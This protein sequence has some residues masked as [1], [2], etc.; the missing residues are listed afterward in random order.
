MR[1]KLTMNLN[2]SFSMA[3]F[4]MVLISGVTLLL[5]LSFASAQSPP[6]GLYGNPNDFMP[7]PPIPSCNADFNQGPP[8][9]PMSGCRATPSR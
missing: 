2:Q 3:M 7:G 8:D 5:S 6:I 4:L 1:N 9:D